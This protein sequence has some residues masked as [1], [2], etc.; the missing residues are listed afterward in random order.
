MG[1]TRHTLTLAALSS[2]AFATEA[3]SAAPPPEATVT[4]SA[5]AVVST[6]AV[7]V[8]VMSVVAASAVG[9]ASVEAT[10]VVPVFE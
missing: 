2:V 6:A 8:G 1:F 7:V 4:V 9:A 3:R 10:N 5:E